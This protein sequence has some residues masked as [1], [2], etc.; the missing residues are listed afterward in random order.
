MLPPRTPSSNPASTNSPANPDSCKSASKAHVRTRFADK[1]IAALDAE[2]L[3]R[4]QD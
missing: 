3:E 2:L 1:R 4:P